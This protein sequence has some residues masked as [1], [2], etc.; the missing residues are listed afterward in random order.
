M[1]RDCGIEVS[2]IENS[3]GQEIQYSCHKK[4]IHYTDEIQAKMM[5]NNTQQNR[6]AILLQEMSFFM[7]N[8]R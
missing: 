7:A 8:Q 4:F 1:Q 2:Y 6:F 3:G 5:E